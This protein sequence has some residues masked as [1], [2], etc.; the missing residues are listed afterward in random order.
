MARIHIY[1][2]VRNEEFML[3]HFLD[4]YAKYADRIFVVD[5]H[6]TDLTAAIAKAHPMV[7]YLEYG[8][9][10]FDE[11]E[12]SGTF[13]SLYATYPSDWAICVDGDEL[14][15]GLETLADE[16]PGVLKCTGYTMVGK[17][18]KLEDC[19]KVRDKG[20]DKPVVFDP[21]LDVRF[22]HGR[23]SVNL[24]ARDSKLE[25]LHYKYPSREYYLK[26]N[27]D[28]YPRIM[29][30]KTTAYRIKRGLEWYDA[31]A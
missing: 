25:L 12:F 5:D 15:Q 27:Q 30:S 21:S 19:K 13:E 20:F 23:H 11:D 1:T 28:L 9:D 24:P 14:I 3:P 26:H 18:G 2:I 6:S 22:G 17:T 7:T 8:F 29:D 4:H 10:G 16:E 31:H